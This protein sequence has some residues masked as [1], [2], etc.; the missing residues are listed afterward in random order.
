MKITA[1]FN[2]TEELVS[3]I[4]AFGSRTEM[5]VEASQIIVPSIEITKK[6]KGEGESENP[7][8]HDVLKESGTRSMADKVD[9]PVKEEIKGSVTPKDDAP[10]VDKKEV[11]KITKEMIRERLGAIMKTGKQ[12]EVKELVAKFGAS[13]VPDLKEEDYAAV[14]KEAEALL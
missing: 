11:V 10:K 14:Y 4:G 6:N 7:M 1:E 8:I 3:F 9:K 2:S 13:K 5:A 12:T